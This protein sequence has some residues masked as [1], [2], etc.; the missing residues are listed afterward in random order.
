MADTVIIDPAFCGPPRSANGGYACGTAASFV[1]GPAT[2]NLRAPPP[3]GR[4][5]Q[6][7]RDGDTVRLV[8]GEVLVAEA[9]PGGP[10][11]DAPTA[12][13]LDVA[14]AASAGYAGHQHHVFPTCFV[15]GPERGEDGLRIFPGPIGDSD[16]VAAAWTPAPELAGPDGAIPDEILWASLDCPGFFATV[17]WPRAA[18]LGQLAARILARPKP[19]EPCVVV[20]WSLGQEGRK[21]H[22][23]TAVFRGGELLALGEAI[24][25]EVDARKA[26][27]I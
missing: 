13:A 4:A 11:I 7:V 5:L 10:S 24:W 3:L 17:A 16:L 8:D 12:P 20:G 23:G 22:A 19:G 26:G 9:R 6:V 2:V 18:V 14:R 1:N 27:F 25:I 21:L 15:C